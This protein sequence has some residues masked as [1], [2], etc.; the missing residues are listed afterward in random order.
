MYIV[1]RIYMKC[2]PQRQH[3]YPRAQDLLDMHDMN[4][5]CYLS[6]KE[7]AAEQPLP[8]QLYS[9]RV[10][11]HWLSTLADKLTYKHKQKQTYFRRNIG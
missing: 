4:E 10:G 3:G 1:N 11:R 6:T 9:V 2:C 8:E 7:L 5:D